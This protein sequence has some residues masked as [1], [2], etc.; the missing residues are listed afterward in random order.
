MQGPLRSLC[1]FY[2]PTSLVHVLNS[3]FYCHDNFLNMQ[4]LFTNTELT[5][6]LSKLNNLNNLHRT[7]TFEE[8][9]TQTPTS[10]P[11]GGNHLAGLLL[12]QTSRLP[13]VA[14]SPD[15]MI[16]YLQQANTYSNSHFVLFLLS[17]DFSY[18]V[19][20]SCMV[21]L[22]H[23]ETSFQANLTWCPQWSWASS[24]ALS[25]RT[26]PTLLPAFGWKWF[27][28]KALKEIACLEHVVSPDGQE[29]SN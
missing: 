20:A 17:L 11:L 7:T 18:W 27:V 6:L 15:S 24:P 5:A 28:N 3:S 13:K 21:T 8:N 1:V 19:Y 10:P 2:D 26:A 4:K 23:T 22:T 25:L 14:L 12:W 9:T 16:A 29:L